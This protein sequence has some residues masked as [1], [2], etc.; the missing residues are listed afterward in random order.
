MIGPL[1]GVKVV[2]FTQIIAGPLSGRL[3]ADM[4]AEVIKLEPPWGEPWRFQ[5]K[6]LPSE[7][8]NFIVY[9]RGKRSL[10]LDLSKPEAREVI[11]RL[12]RSTD[13]T[14]MNFRP[15]VAAKL[16]IDYDT[17]SEINPRLVYCEITAYGREGPDSDRPGYDMILQ[18]MSGLMASEAKIQ[19]GV[20]QQI[21]A[22]ALIDTTSGVNLAGC[23]C[24]ALYAREKTGVGQR[25]ETSLLGS[26]LTLLGS[27]FLNVDSYDL[28]TRNKALADIATKRAESAPYADQ[29]EASPGS[30]RQR[31]HANVYYRIYMTQDGPIGVGCLSDPLRKRLLVTLGLEDIAFE[32]GYDPNT[33]ES[34]AYADNLTKQAEA[35]FREKSSVEW[36]QILENNGIPTGPVRF[37]EELFDD[38]QIKA[39]G[40][41]SQS[42]HRDAG[43]VTMM[44]PP[45]KFMGTPTEAARPSP[46][47]GEHTEEILLELGFSREDYDSWKSSGIIS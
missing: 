28:E 3:L 26:S 12:I 2:D 41:V 30:R 44:G 20:P 9:N 22:S 10:P 38:P 8:R 21:F 36:F 27:R 1:H 16:G 29:L 43:T 11:R 42:E 7:S 40:L 19:D 33:P 6:F 32:P 18:A 39:N 35:L 45:A 4:G 15:D 5:Q 23:V 14:L 47:L 37:V 46:A 24:A 34:I 25:V 17:F 31:H 13:V